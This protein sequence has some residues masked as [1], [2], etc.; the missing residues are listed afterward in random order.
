MKKRNGNT[1][2]CFMIKEKK[3]TNIKTVWKGNIYSL[4]EDT[5]LHDHYGNHC[6]I[7]FKSYKPTSNILRYI[8]KRFHIL[9]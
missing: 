1:L 3:L 5:N 6:G 9:L 8:T 4:G 2:T 7:S